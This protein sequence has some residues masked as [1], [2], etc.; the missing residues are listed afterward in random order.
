MKSCDDPPLV[1]SSRVKFAPLSTA[2]TGALE[3]QYLSFFQGVAAN[4]FTNVSQAVWS[5]QAD[6][7]ALLGYQVRKNSV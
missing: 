1:A 5:L 6:K 4:G 2:V 3:P 7:I